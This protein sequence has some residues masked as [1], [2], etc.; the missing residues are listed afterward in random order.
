MSK[1]KFALAYAVKNRK[2]ESKED[3]LSGEGSESIEDMMNIEHDDFLSGEGHDEMSDADV[4]LF[5]PPH[6]DQGSTLTRIM[7]KRMRPMK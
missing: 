2:P 1:S 3:Y 6:E 7:K 4:D 5:N